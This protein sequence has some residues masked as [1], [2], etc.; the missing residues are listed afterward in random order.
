MDAEARVGE[1]AT[2]S[3]AVFPSLPTRLMWVFVSPGRLMGRLAE[4]PVW[5]GALLVSTVLVVLSVALIPVEVF[6]EVNREAAI[7]RG[8]EFPEMGEGALSFMRVFIPASAALSTVVFSLVFAGVYTVI[9]AFIL[10][11]EGSYRQYLAALSHAWFIAALL[12]LL[13]T[14][15]KIA[16]E[17]PQLTLNLGL[18]MPFLPEGYLQSFFRLLDITQIWSTLVLAQGAHAI[19]RRRSFGSAATILLSITVFVVAILARF[20]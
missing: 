4:N 13:I 9:F 17:D 15:L 7:E 2:G 16:A 6:M 14:P 19:D 10:G 5:A 20:I 18:F 12:G 8:G 3:E 11:D 1:P